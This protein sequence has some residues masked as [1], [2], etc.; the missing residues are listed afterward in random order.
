MKRGMNITLRIQADLRGDM[1]ENREPLRVFVTVDPT[2]IVRCKWC[3]VA[4]SENWQHTQVGVFC[5]TACY[6]AER[7]D[8]R[9][10][11]F[12][13]LVILLAFPVAMI[14][15]LSPL[16]FAI[17][18]PVLIL[19]VSPIL[20]CGAVG[21]DLRKKVPRDS[22]RDDVTSDLA[23]LKAISSGVSC[24]KCS[25]NIDVRKIGTDRVYNCEYCGASGTVEVVKTSTTTTA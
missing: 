22:R 17:G 8:V 9:I 18:L 10:G 16:A 7:A 3:G 4:Q 15:Q 1:K 5:S 24:P 13:S 23:L 25:A 6:D 11:V 19:A 12:F 2:K 21:R 20:Y 14:A